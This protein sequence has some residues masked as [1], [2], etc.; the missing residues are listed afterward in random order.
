MK[1]AF[2]AFLFLFALAA[3]GNKPNTLNPEYEGILKCNNMEGKQVVS[4]VIPFYFSPSLAQLFNAKYA[5]KI[6]D[7]TFQNVGSTFGTTGKDDTYANQIPLKNKWKY[8]RR[9]RTFDLELV[10][11]APVQIY[12]GG[13]W[14]LRLINFYLGSD[15]GPYLG[16]FENEE[17]GGYLFAKFSTGSDDTK[18]LCRFNF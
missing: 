8:N 13:D 12:N 6:K 18:L 7:L 16:A 15:D 9:A 4:A 14:N 10:V 5:P 2:T 11:K 1:N 17:S 3:H